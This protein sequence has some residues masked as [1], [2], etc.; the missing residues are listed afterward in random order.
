M[1]RSCTGCTQITR[2]SG[3]FCLRHQHG[4]C[5]EL[6]LV[7]PAK[8]LHQFECKGQCGGRALRGDAVAVNHDGL[9]N[10]MQELVLERWIAGGLFAIEQAVGGQGEGRC[11]TKSADPLLVDALFPQFF[12]QGRMLAQVFRAFFS[13][14]QNNQVKGDISNILEEDIGREGDVACSNDGEF[15]FNTGN[16]DAHSGA[17]QDVDEGYGFDAFGAV[18]NRHEGFHVLLIPLVGLATL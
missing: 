16:R 12:D 7:F 1:A 4:L 5:D 2:E 8:K 10:E 15:R 6:A 3:C 18:G 13:A 9:I 11:R 14:R 17:A